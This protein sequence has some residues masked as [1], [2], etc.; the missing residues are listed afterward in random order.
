MISDSYSLKYT[1]KLNEKAEGYIPGKIYPLNDPTTVSYTDENEE[2]QTKDIPVPQ[3]AMYSAEYIYVSGTPGMEL[4]KTFIPVPVDT[5][6]YAD[7]TDV[8]AKAP[9]ALIF[10]DSEQNGVWTF[11][12]WDENVKKI[13]GKNITF[14]GEWTFSANPADPN[15]SIPDTGDNS[16]MLWLGLTVAFGSGIIAVALLGKKGRAD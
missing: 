7:K 6:S 10:T 3:G 16:M 13:D 12:A 8:D 9:E 5:N 4:P 11:K 1:V 14:I 15:Q 2:R